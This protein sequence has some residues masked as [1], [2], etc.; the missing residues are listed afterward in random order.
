MRY[1]IGFLVAV[2]PLLVATPAPAQ[3]INTLRGFDDQEMGW[4][5]RAESTVAFAEGNNEYFEFE[6][7]GVVQ[8]M[9]ERHRW[10]LLGRLMRRT[11]GPVEVAQTRLGHLRHNYRLLPWLA[12]VAFAQGQYDPFRRIESR[13]LLGAGLRF[14]VIRS[15]TWSAA[16]GATYMYE[17]EELTG[18]DTES[19]DTQKHRL[20]LFLSVF[21]ASTQ[22]IQLDL[23][24]FYQPVITD[25]SDAR[26]L[27]LAALRIDIVGELYFLTRSGLQFNSRPPPG[28]ERT[29]VT[30]RSG[31]G[32]GF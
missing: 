17:D 14:D 15:L 3:I 29:D 1:T 22:N 6:L 19:T 27:G 24:G 16:F 4:S 26:A 2:L 13:V 11:A 23:S 30:L 10:R 18:V 9:S 5:G 8:H 20:S 31:L 7:S 32:I 28:V 21:S 25:W 12:T